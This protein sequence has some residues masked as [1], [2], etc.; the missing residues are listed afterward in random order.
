MPAGRPRKHDPVTIRKGI[1]QCFWQL[2]FD[3]ASLPELEEAAGINRKQLARDFGN[4]R[5]LYLQAI[6]DFAVFAGDLFVAP[7]EQ[8]DGGVAAIRQ[9]LCS[10]ADLPRRPDGHLG[11]LICNASREPIAKADDEVAERIR[12]YFLRIEVGYQKALEGAWAKG[13]AAIDPDRLQATARHLFAVH[14]ALLV[15]VRSGAKKP[16]LDDIAEQALASLRPAK[17]QSH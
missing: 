16:V 13:E 6:D 5:G 17:T 15:L 3:R 4:K 7:L 12:A 1:M 10:L 14:V 9:V 8:T 11:C 2:G